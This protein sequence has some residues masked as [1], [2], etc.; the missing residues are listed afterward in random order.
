MLAL[1][2]DTSA[3][4]RAMCY[5]CY[6]ESLSLSTRHKTGKNSA[7]CSGSRS[8]QRPSLRRG[9]CLRSSMRLSLRRDYVKGP[10][11]FAKAR[12]GEAISLERDGLSLKTQST[13]LGEYSRR[14]PGRGPI[15]LA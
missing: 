13:R 9:E 7:A 2:V 10:G 4:P 6:N 8:S 15:I 3:H 5:N 1:V 11:S 12:L 14:T